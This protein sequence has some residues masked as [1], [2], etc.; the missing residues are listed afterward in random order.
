[1][2]PGVWFGPDT[3]D[4]VA[5][6]GAID[7]TIVGSMVPV[8]DRRSFDRMG[9][10]FVQC[11]AKYSSQCELPLLLSGGR[12]YFGEPKFLSSSFLHLSKTV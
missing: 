2:T 10:P 5:G 6:H 1:M 9:L 4:K 11:G 3:Y 8:C 12:C 7:E